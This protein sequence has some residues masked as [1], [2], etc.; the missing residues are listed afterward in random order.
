MLCVKSQHTK[1]ARL[2]TRS[3]SYFTGLTVADYTDDDLDETEDDTD[4]TSKNNDD[5][6]TQEEAAAFAAYMKAKYDEPNADPAEVERMQDA[7]WS[8]RKKCLV[9]EDHE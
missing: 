2:E 8:L 5:G 3:R 6:E 4:D 7:W 9:Y 1:H